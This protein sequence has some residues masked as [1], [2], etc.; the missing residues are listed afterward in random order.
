MRLPKLLAALLVLF[1]LIAWGHNC[2]NLMMEIDEIL[3]S[4][5]DLDEETII[6]ED[7]VKNVKQLREEGEALH[8]AGKH[9][10]SVEMLNKA[11]ELLEN[12]T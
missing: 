7:N 4:K 10:E 11:L 5:P 9:D 8:K 2:P 1:P 6:D 3:E 12:E